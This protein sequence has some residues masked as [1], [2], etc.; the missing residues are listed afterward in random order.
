MHS[1][2]AGVPR[3][4]GR[5]RTTSTSLFTGYTEEQALRKHGGATPKGIHARGHK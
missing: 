3:T 2:G 5:R 4:T 1:Y